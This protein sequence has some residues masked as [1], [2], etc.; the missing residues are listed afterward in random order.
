[1]FPAFPYRPTTYVSDVFLPSLHSS[2]LR[3][4]RSLHCKL[5]ASSAAPQERNKAHIQLLVSLAGDSLA[6][7]RSA[8]QRAAAA[9]QRQLT[10][11]LGELLA[12]QQRLASE[13]STEAEAAGRRVLGDIRWTA[14]DG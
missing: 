13:V 8:Q 10:P 9:A 2:S 6:L 1:M 11:L 3:V 4:F 5:N 7:S 12:A 14:V